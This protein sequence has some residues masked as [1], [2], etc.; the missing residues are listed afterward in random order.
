MRALFLAL[1]IVLAACGGQMTPEEEAE[2]TAAAVAEVR[3][4]NEPPA[5]IVD[6]EPMSFD[7][8]EQADIFGVSCSFIP[9]D[10]SP[11]PVA[12][13]L[14]DTAY[15]KIDGMIEPFAPDI[16]SPDSPF[17]TKTKFDST[18]RSMEWTIVCSLT[19]Y[20]KPLTCMTETEMAWFQRW[21]HT[22]TQEKKPGRLPKV[23]NVRPPMLN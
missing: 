15:A 19:I 20:W 21:K 3:K 2:A 10:G 4:A 11:D 1:P 6:P 5:I 8:I 13:A 9:D 14:M 12:I 23:N 22:T 18:R 16:G 7:D 17:G